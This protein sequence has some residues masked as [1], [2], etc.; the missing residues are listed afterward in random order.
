MISLKI[1]SI[2]SN[3]TFNGTKNVKRLISTVTNAPKGSNVT[4]IAKLSSSV[5]MAGM[6]YQLLKIK[7]YNKKENNSVD[8]QEEVIKRILNLHKKI[9]EKVDAGEKITTEDITKH[10][11][12]EKM[13]AGRLP[14]FIERDYGDFYNEC[15]YLDDNIIELADFKKEAAIIKNK[16]LKK[17]AETICKKEQLD[18]VFLDCIRDVDAGLSNITDAK[19]LKEIKPE[20]KRLAEID[21]DIEHYDDPK[22]GELEYSSSLNRIIQMVDVYNTM[23]G[24]YS[25]YRKAE[26]TLVSVY[27]EKSKP[28][29]FINH[30]KESSPRN[31]EN[32]IKALNTVGAEKNSLVA[33]F[34]SSLK[35]EALEQLTND[36]ELLDYMYERYY[37]SKITDAPAKKLCREISHTYGVRVLLSNKTKDIRRALRVIK[38]ELEDWTKVSGGK[39]Y[40]PSI[41]DLNSCEF[42]YESH[43]AY[44]D[45]K[46]N[47]YHNGA[48]I[49]SPKIIRH[50][51][52]H[53]N[54]GSMFAKYSSD[55]ELVKLIRSIIASKKEVVNGREKEVLDYDNCKY[56]E[57]F[58]K[59]GIDSGHIEY[60]Y[61]NKN[62]FLAVAAEGDLSEYSPEFKEVLIKM[63]MPEYVFNLPVDD[64]NVEINVDRVKEILEEHPNATYDE[65]V[66]YIE[67]WKA[68]EISPQDKLLSA[69]FGKKWK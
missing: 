50:E 58:L 11:R 3:I 17:I 25:R 10:L 7:E 69:I 34:E 19:I 29:V 48:K 30:I 61:T 44:T 68:K 40:L 57:E 55:P 9:Q 36:K 41:L 66:K 42:L 45:I 16:Q 13:E 27:M 64:I 2:N 56:R 46:G 53:L 23:S 59:A 20:L 32:F 18:K 24:K 22:N 43:H 5:G 51:I 4:P 62:E 12:S 52:M 15:I 37:L 49:N 21:Y 14:D 31:K 65:L 6:M 8:A 67:E 63:G 33:D 39:A 26:I 1:N 47:I 35:T 38:Q 28:A 54:E 60:A